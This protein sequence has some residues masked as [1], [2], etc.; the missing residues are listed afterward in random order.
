MSFNEKLS[1]T[2]HVVTTPTTDFPFGFQFIEGV[3]AVRVLVNDVDALEAG[4]AIRLKND[5]TM[6]VQPAVESGIVRIY[7]ETNIDSSM[8]RFTAGAKFVASNVDANFEQILHSQQEVRDQFIKLRS[9]TFI[10]L[11]EF[12]EENFQELKEYV[13]GVFGMTNPNLFDGITDNMVID[14]FGE[15]QRFNNR[16]FRTRLN[17]LE[18]SMLE[19]QTDKADLE[20]VNQKFALFALE[21]DVAARFELKANITY[22]DQALAGVAGGLAA[23]FKTLADATAGMVGKPANTQANVTNDPDAT[24]NGLYHWDGSVLT[25]SAYDPYNQAISWFV[26]Q[27]PATE[28]GNLHTESMVH[29]DWNLSLSDVL[30][31]PSANCGVSV[32]PVSAGRYYIKVPSATYTQ[33][34]RV[35]GHTTPDLVNNKACTPYTLNATSDPMIKYI[36]VPAGLPYLFIN[37]YWQAF[38]IDVRTTLRVT[39][40]FPE[41]QV[42]KI[43]GYPV[44]DTNT[45][46][47]LTDHLDQKPLVDD[48]LEITGVQLYNPANNVPNLYLDSTTGTMTSIGNNQGAITHFPV[49]PNTTYF[50]RA[51]KFLPNPIIGLRTDTTATNGTTTTRIALQLVESGVYKFT[52]PSDVSLAHAFFTVKLLTQ[53]YDITAELTVDTGFSAYLS[54]IRGYT[55]GTDPTIN[56]RLAELEAI[57]AAIDGVSSLHGIN[58]C[59]I[60]DSI[61]EKNFR[62]VK[63]YH[64]YVADLVG[65][66]NIF[67]YGISGTAWTQ[68]TNVASQIQTAITNGTHA[69]PD[70]FTVF[71]GTNDFGIVAKPIGSFL[72]ET[73]DTVAGGINLLLKNLITQFPLQ[74]MAVF[75]PLTRGNNYGMNAT[76]NSQGVTLRQICDMI[77]LHC[78]HYGIPVLDLYKVNNLKVYNADANSY[79]FRYPNGAP[80]G[81]HPNDA[82]H[83]SL[84]VIIRRFL[85]SIL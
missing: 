76:P 59:C 70:L 41:L 5:V 50:L 33:Y 27:T 8:Y 51:S 15:S 38:S 58:W 56:T 16:S 49:Q 31:T 34:F 40:I 82:G 61:T 72:D 4:Y 73:T 45:Y 83:K 21:S 30:R 11:E 32:L 26:S 28:I 17:T 74:K 64:E 66:L 37:S 43:R 78:D 1:Y 46:K 63:N 35:A 77:I 12:Q 6:E 62:T 85:E 55:V 24:K 39:R 18:A 48:D 80:D 52:T 71:L 84:A 14:E 65:G 44:H 13:D 10:T 69:M 29:L 42:Q 2:E 7:R 67:N 75:T 47:A 68:R 22:V 19:V 25:K 54:S 20:Y 3:D 36:D 53:S 60:G 79:F 23:T 81:V 9:D 57:V